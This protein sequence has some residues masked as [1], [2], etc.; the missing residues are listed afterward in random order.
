L[1]TI[2]VDGRVYRALIMCLPRQHHLHHV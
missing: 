2:A 1:L